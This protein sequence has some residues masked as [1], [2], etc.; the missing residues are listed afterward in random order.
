MAKKYVKKEPPNNR[1]E[2]DTLV[3]KDAEQQTVAPKHYGHGAVYV[4]GSV[5]E[6]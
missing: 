1:L 4:D 6:E 5:K 3:I 2:A